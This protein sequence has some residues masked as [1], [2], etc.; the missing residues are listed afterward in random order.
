MSK[1]V[2]NAAFEASKLPRIRGVD[3]DRI[4]AAL[5]LLTGAKRPPTVRAGWLALIL[6]LD[7]HG[8]PYPA[9]EI[10]AAYLNT[11]KD[12]VDSAKNTSLALGLVTKKSGYVPGNNKQWENVVEQTFY[13]PTR[14]LQQAVAG[15]IASPR[16]QIKVASR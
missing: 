9:R 11:T 7:R 1:K 15:P 4:E 10:V 13:V 3:Q 2:E 14:K 16:P 8:I 12:G 5:T 6:E